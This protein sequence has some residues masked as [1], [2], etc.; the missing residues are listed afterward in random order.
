ML[1]S[2]RAL[3]P[4]VARRRF[5]SQASSARPRHAAQARTALLAA[6]AVVAAG[7]LWYATRDVIHND[8]AVDT[9]D[10]AS[11]SGVVSGVSLEDGSL[12]TLVWGSNK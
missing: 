8:G 9:K 6:S 5:F 7:S 2:S 12:S 1:R 11:K 3:A 4:G 10:G